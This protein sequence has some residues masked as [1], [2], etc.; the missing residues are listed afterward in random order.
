MKRQ[1]IVAALLALLAGAPLA[2]GPGGSKAVFTCGTEKEPARRT[3]GRVDTW[4]FSALSFTPDFRGMKPLLIPYKAIT[5]LEFGP[6]PGRRAEA[7]LTP[8]CAVKRQDRYLTIFYKVSADVK[9][10]EGTPDSNDSKDAKVSKET[11]DRQDREDRRDRKNQKD[12]KDQK[13]QAAKKDEFEKEKEHV[14]VFELGESVLRPTLKII[15]TRSGKRIT[16]QDVDARK[17]AR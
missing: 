7:I 15:E 13:D 8:P 11:K 12:V 14:A 6:T 4:N 2:A 3:E 16:Y 5:R 9:Q 1:A 10:E 17:A